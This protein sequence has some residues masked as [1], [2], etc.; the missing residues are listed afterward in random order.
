MIV[1]NINIDP[2]FHSYKINLEKHVLIKNTSTST[3]QTSQ[4]S[5]TTEKSTS[6]FILVSSILIYGPLLKKLRNRGKK[7]RR[8]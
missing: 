4:S 5:G 1:E 6:G 2:G 3:I 7:K 8:P